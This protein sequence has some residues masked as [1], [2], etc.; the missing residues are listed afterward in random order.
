MKEDK[1]KMDAKRAV[2][3]CFTYAQESVGGSVLTHKPSIRGVALKYILHARGLTLA[4]TAFILRMSKQRMNY[5]CNRMTD[6]NFDDELGAQMC[7]MLH[8][9]K[10]YFDSL[11][12]EIGK[13]YGGSG[14]K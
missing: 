13:I 8:I 14:Q 1:I 5:I 2:E 10:E 3:F 12:E 9:N 7:E 6:R 4:K 11:C